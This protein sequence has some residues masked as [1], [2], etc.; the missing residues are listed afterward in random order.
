MVVRGSATLG[1]GANVFVLGAG[2]LFLFQPGQDHELLEASADL[3]LFV[4][5]L[6]PELAAKLD[7]VSRQPASG[8]GRLVQSE[9][10]PLGD[11]LEAIRSLADVNA[12]EISIGGL[13]ERIQPCLDRG[14]VLS[15]RA[16]TQLQADPSVS[17]TKLA[18]RLNAS[19][20]DVSRRFHGDV[21]VRFVEYRAR[22]R[23]HREFVRL[24]DSGQNLIDAA[25]NADFG[26]YAQCHRVFQRVLRCA[27]QR[28]SLA[29]VVNWMKRSSWMK[30]P[31]WVDFEPATSREQPISGLQ[32]AN[33]G[34]G[35]TRPPRASD[36]LRLMHA[37]DG[38]GRG[39]AIRPSASKTQG[40]CGGDVSLS[41]Q[42]QKL[43]D[44]HSDL[45]HGKPA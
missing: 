14:H 42:L 22:L 45:S 20:S 41:G 44:R 34:S 18:A 40:A 15:R 16:V 39:S 36:G 8:A 9:L 30:A 2:E 5:A 13:F 29:H 19:P 12:V 17:G 11:K 27:P 37:R 25:L 10:A 1:V 26:S 21:G 33:E 43:H 6:R 3:E 24:V 28:T 32:G 35:L 23:A 4:F 7:G 31:D 38:Q